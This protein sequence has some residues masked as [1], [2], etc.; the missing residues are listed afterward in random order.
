MIDYSQWRVSCWIICLLTLIRYA[1]KYQSYAEINHEQLCRI[2][3]DLKHTEETF[4]RVS[5]EL[6]RA[7]SKSRSRSRSVRSR[8][9]SPTTTT[10]TT[11]K[12]QPISPRN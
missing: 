5:R 6:K 9:K 12:N 8:C 11:E 7:R 3:A 10:T 1:W 4:A 2:R